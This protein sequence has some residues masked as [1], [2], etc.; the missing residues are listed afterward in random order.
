MSPK[1]ILGRL[2]NIAF[3][4]G[5]N[6][7]D[8]MRSKFLDYA[9]YQHVFISNKAK[10][11]IFSDKKIIVAEHIEG[12]WG[13]CLDE[14]NSGYNN[15]LE[16]ERDIA[17][18]ASVI[19][20][21]LEGFG[22]AV[23]TGAFFSNKKLKEKLIIIIREKH[24]DDISFIQRAIIVGLPS[25]RNIIYYNENDDNMNQKIF[26]AIFS[27]RENQNH[28][29]NT[30]TDSTI[31]LYFFLLS[32]L[33]EWKS[34]EEIIRELNCKDELKKYKEKID[35]YLN[36]LQAV[37]L[38]VKE[39]NFNKIKF[40]SL[41]RSDCILEAL[42]PENIIPNTSIFK[43][44]VEQ[45]RSDLVLLKYMKKFADTRCLFYS[46]HK[47]PHTKYKSPEQP[48]ESLQKI[49]KTRILSNK[50]VFSVHKSATAYVKTG[51]IKKNVERYCKNQ[52]ILKLDFRYFFSSIKRSDFL[53]Y[54]RDTKQ[55]YRP[56]I[57]LIC[58]ITFKDDSI[59]DTEFMLPIGASTSPIISNILL[60][61]FDEMLS[62][63]SKSLGI[64]YT[65]YGDDL[66]FSCNEL[67][68][69]HTLENKVRD[70]LKKIPYPSKLQINDKKTLYMS[71]KGRRKITG[72]YITPE[73]KI[74]I[75]RNRKS[76]I[77]K[78]LRDFEKGINKDRFPYIQGYLSFVRGVEKDFW[79]RLHDKYVTKYGQK[80]TSKA[81]EIYELFHQNI[82]L[83]R[84]HPFGSFGAE[85]WK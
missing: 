69:L 11:N 10:E 34:K 57:E 45:T 31:A 18:L 43:N 42:R 6:D 54:L 7:K 66:T 23:E 36:I 19:P 60:Y 28:P 59:T 35:N 51:N 12:L 24:F 64:T 48:L 55:D 49:L 70:S 67:N 74:S 21:F 17:E 26:E 15:L 77:K 16:L 13:G 20:I 46:Y 4:C 27:F 82:H 58:D 9:K 52:F 50:E 25:S 83:A 41:L 68:K 79:E 22:A 8:S 71:K 73:G 37:G 61:S 38:I 84:K 80:N 29:I 47:P 40:L 14:T 56:Y 39:P 44:V 72:L 1:H 30:K 2:P 85:R 33:C 75:G 5:G 3:L 62:E 53:K 65:R 63:Y 32:I 78:L 76:Y 81:R